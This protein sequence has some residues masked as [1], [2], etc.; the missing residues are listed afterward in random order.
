MYPTYVGYMMSKRQNFCHI[1][2]SHGVACPSYS[3]T[4]IRTG[5]ESVM[6]NRVG[7]MFAGRSREDGTVTEVTEDGVTVTYKDGT[8]EGFRLGTQYGAAAGLTIPHTLTTDVKVGQ[9]V[10]A[11]EVVTYNKDYFVKDRYSGEY[12]YRAATYVNVVVYETGLTNE[13]SSVISQRLADKL[14]TRTTKVRDIVLEFGQEVRDLVKVGQTVEVDDVLCVIEDSVTANSGV[15]DKES[16]DTLRLL[17]SQTPTAKVKGTVERI[18][19]FY[20]GDLEDMSESLRKLAG[21]Y[22]RK[23]AREARAQG[24]TPYT[25]AVNE[26]FRIEGNPLLLD[27]LVVRVYITSVVSAASGDKGVFAHQMKTVFGE[28]MEEPIIAEDGTEIDAQFGRRS[29]DARIVNSPDLVGTTITL[30]EVIGKKAVE[31]YDK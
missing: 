8:T 19:V 22:N 7:K 24:K 11:G 20:N 17:G 16:L 5:Y 29:I 3:P 18:E 31:I 23:L 1:Q 21:E 14:A 27:S 10:K 2:A 15:F 12:T 13:D 25:G 6:I 9:K 26:G 30:L 4:P 28:V